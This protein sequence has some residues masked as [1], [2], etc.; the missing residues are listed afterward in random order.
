M[1]NF[2]I[3]IIAAAFCCQAF[4][5][6]PRQIV[7]IEKKQPRSVDIS[8]NVTV[9]IG[10]NLF[11]FDG[12]DS[13]VIIR[14]GDQELNILDSPDEKKV[15]IKN[16]D[17]ELFDLEEEARKRHHHFQKSD[18]NTTFTDQ[19]KDWE[20]EES[21]RRGR[22]FR[23]HWAGLEAGFNNYL[24]AGSITLP[25][26]ISYMKLITGKSNCFNLNFSQA[27]IGFSRHTGLVTGVGLNW[28]IY[29][30]EGL[31]SIAVDSD[32]I[33]REIVP[34]N[35][36]PVKKSKFNTL[37]LNIP[38]MFEIQIP[39]GYN[40]LNIA[41]GLIGGVKLNAWT[42]LIFEDGEKVR[43]NGDYG[44]NLLRGG[45][46]ARLGYENFM[47]YGTCYKT[48]W[49]QDLKG[50]DGYNLEPFEIGLALTFNN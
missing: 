49:F 47:I 24:H 21:Y 13:L 40:R 33:I 8:D 28:N 35:T 15:R 48:P 25:E 31:N 39:A 11:R 16:Y 38:L 7:V 26:Q 50:P 22:N 42:K 5:M 14:I 27:N 18:E 23:G 1:K 32:N 46:T 12:N 2:I 36:V 3:V 34:D 17:D 41:A 43:T 45:I 4:T 10:D 9:I 20:E 19:D 6:Q 37:Y 30:F 44:L 29:R